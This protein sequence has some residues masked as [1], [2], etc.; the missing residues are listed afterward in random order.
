MIVRRHR[1][2]YSHG[3]KEKFVIVIKECFTKV[4]QAVIR[5]VHLTGQTSPAGNQF[6]N[7][8][9]CIPDM[10][11]EKALVVAHTMGSSGEW[12]LGMM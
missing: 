4:D 3:E 5:I 1:W 11:A 12:L 2:W 10:S 9:G 6:D 7:L 8:L